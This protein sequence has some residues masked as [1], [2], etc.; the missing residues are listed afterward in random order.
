[1]R[2]AHKVFHSIRLR[3]IIEARSGG[4]Q[5][6]ASYKGSLDNF[7]V[8]FRYMSKDCVSRRGQDTLIQWTCLH[9]KVVKFD[10]FE[11]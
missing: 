3:L 5:K 10:H 11:I 4:P 8:Y 7:L 6:V 1:M 9:S 2:I